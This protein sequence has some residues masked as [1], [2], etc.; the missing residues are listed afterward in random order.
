MLN[1]EGQ[2]ASMILRAQGDAK[3]K[4]MAAEAEKQSLEIVAKGRIGEGP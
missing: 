3:A 4:L 2:R 1:A